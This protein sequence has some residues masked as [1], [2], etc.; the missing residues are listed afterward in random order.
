MLKPHPSYST[1]GELIVAAV[2]FFATLGIVIS[3]M[4]ASTRVHDIPL[5]ASAPDTLIRLPS[6]TPCQPRRRRLAHRYT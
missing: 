4:D 5:A 1:A 3:A 2:L 6:A